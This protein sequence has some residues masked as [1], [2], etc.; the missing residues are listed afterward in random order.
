MCWIPQLAYL[1]GSSDEN[2][3]SVSASSSGLGA[4]MDIFNAE[5]FTI[6]RVRFHAAEMR[7]GDVTR[8]NKPCAAVKYKAE[9]R[10]TRDGTKHPGMEIRFPYM[11]EAVYEEFLLYD[12]NA[13]V[14][15]VGGSLGLFLG[16]SCLGC[17]GQILD[18]AWKA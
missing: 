4:C 13:I 11:R 18:L 6:D 14:A 5:D 1:L 7:F 8:C 10:D 16:F 12:L 15:G 9:V 17:L 3:A 2:N